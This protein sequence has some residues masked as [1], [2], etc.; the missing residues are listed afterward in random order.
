MLLQSVCRTAEV[1]PRPGLSAQALMQRVVQRAWCAGWSC[2]AGQPG[3]GAGSPGAGS[4]QCW[5]MQLALRPL[6]PC[7]LL[8][9]PPCQ[10]AA[11]AARLPHGCQE[12]LHRYMSVLVR[13]LLLP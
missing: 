4:C 12:S 7:A 3:A 1:Q 8:E 13:H 11:A 2:P 5:P 6:S 10:R 9:M